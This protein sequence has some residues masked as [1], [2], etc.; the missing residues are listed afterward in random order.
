MGGGRADEVVE[1]AHAH[2]L[3][4]NC[5]TANTREMAEKAMAIGCDGVITNY[6]DWALLAAG[7]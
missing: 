2:G 6:P 1:D 5:W 7:R 3:K 4:V